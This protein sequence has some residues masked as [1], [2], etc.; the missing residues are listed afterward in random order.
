ME[1]ASES[2][3]RPVARIPWLPFKVS[4]VKPEDSTFFQEMM[5]C[6]KEGS[7]R[8]EF[9]RILTKTFPFYLPKRYNLLFI[10]KLIS[11]LN[12]NLFLN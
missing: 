1:P 12:I 4:K 9:Y 3:Q 6:G 2:G 7:R 11:K 5:T 8:L 10:I